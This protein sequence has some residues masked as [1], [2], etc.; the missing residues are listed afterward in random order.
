MYRFYDS[1]KMNALETHYVVVEYDSEKNQ[2]S[3]RGTL[4]SSDGFFIFQSGESTKIENICL[5]LR[6]NKKQFIRFYR[7]KILVNPKFLERFP[8][9]SIS[10]NE[11]IYKI[12]KELDKDLPVRNKWVPFVFPDN[13]DKTII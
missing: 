3:V 5:F 8:T 9:L 12:Q 7:D 13:N 6:D 1:S 11:N 10:L 4:T 2:Y